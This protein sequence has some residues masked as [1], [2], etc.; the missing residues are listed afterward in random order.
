MLKVPRGKVELYWEASNLVADRM[1]SVGSA[2]MTVHPEAHR[3]LSRKAGIA[4]AIPKC[5]QFFA[6]YGAG[7]I[8]APIVLLAKGAMM[9]ATD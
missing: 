2:P 6:Y 3:T 8:A 5:F 1:P 4:D 7:Q 9:L